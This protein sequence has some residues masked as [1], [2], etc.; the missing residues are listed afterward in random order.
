MRNYIYTCL[1][2]ICLAGV[3]VVVK[4]TDADAFC[5]FNCSPK[6]SE[7]RQIFHNKL[8]SELSKPAKIES[9]TK[10]NGQH[11]KFFGVEGYI[12]HFKAKITFP[13]GAKVDDCRKSSHWCFSSLLLVNPVA[14]ALQ[15]TMKISGKKQ[16]FVIKPGQSILRYG[17]ILFDKTE[18]GWRGQVAP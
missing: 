1:Y 6:V 7:A 15:Q 2:A 4:T 16:P 17:K 12:L 3:L 11:A 14:L 9:F 13:K 5:L 10:T 8:L 18:R